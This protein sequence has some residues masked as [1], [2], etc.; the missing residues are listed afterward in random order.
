[1]TIT[2][3]IDYQDDDTQ[4]IIKACLHGNSSAERL[5]LKQNLGFAKLVTSR[6]VANTEEGEE[7]VNDGFLKVFQNLGKYQFDQPFKAWVRT[8]MVRTAIDYY[9]KNLK[10]HELVPLDDIEVANIGSDVISKISTSEI[11]KLIQRLSPAYRMVF[12]MY[13]L[14]GYN[15]KEIA[16]MLDIKEGTSK[17]NLQ[18]AR[19]KLQI[20]IKKLYPNLY[21]AHAL[22]TSKINEN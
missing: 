17:S 4:S 11:L 9:R 10:H 5:L 1:M 13:V 7:I 18:D 14:D 20:M 21:L 19:K 3:N 22:N 8:I 6:Y 12:T 15:H 2:K 16:S